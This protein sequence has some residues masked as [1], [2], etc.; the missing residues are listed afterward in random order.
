MPRA[1]LLGSDRARTLLALG[2][3]LTSLGRYAEAE[4]LLLES[5]EILD[6]GDYA[7][8]MRAEPTRAVVRLYEAQGRRAEAAKY[9]RLLVPSPA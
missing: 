6:R 3:C 7:A 2:T 4:P 8:A 9:R 5:V 1:Q